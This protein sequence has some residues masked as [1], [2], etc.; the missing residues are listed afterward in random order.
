MELIRSRED[1]V[2]LAKA[3]GQLVIGNESRHDDESVA[4]PRFL[5][6]RRLHAGASLVGRKAGGNLLPP[7]TGSKSYA[8]RHGH[9][10]D[11]AH[12]TKVPRYAGTDH[13]GQCACSQVSWTIRR[14]KSSARALSAALASPL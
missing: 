10:A 9:D 3:R 14:S 7:I 4:I 11:I 8:Q 13:S 5:E 6:F 1:F 12:E 2:E